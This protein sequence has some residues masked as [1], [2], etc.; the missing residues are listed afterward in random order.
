MS[1]TNPQEIGLDSAK[2]YSKIDS[3][4]KLAIEVEATPGMQV[5]IAKDGKVFFHKAYGHH[6][7]DKNREV[8]LT[9]VYDLAS[10]TK[11]AGPL[12]ALMKLH[13]Q[14]KFKLDHLFERLLGELA[15][16]ETNAT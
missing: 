1:Y 6:T 12:P 4:A 9:D 14:R 11:I 2:L 15:E 5:L 7:Y 10:I 3:I 16:R 13:D 8:E